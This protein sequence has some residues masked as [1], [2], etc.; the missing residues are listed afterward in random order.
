MLASQ[1]NVQRIFDF[2]KN[3]SE[4]LKRPVTYSEA[5]ALWIS[6]T[7]INKTS[8]LKKIDKLSKDVFV[9]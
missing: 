7:M 1:E 8:K 5:I 6:Q 9:Y 2:Q 3:K 4:E